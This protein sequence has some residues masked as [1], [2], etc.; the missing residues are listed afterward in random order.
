MQVLASLLFLFQAVGARVGVLVGARL[1][2]A[3]R[4]LW[5]AGKPSLDYS[6]LHSK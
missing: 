2:V 1:K 3:L 4:L 5:S 6:G